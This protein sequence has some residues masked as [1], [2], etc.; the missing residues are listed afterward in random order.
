MQLIISF[1]NENKLDDSIGTWNRERNGRKGRKR[2]TNWKAK[3]GERKSIQR[4]SNSHVR[5]DQL[6]CSWSR[7]V[8]W[9]GERAANA[10]VEK[11]KVKVEFAGLCRRPE[12]CVCRVLGAA[13]GYISLSGRRKYR[14]IPGA[15]PREPEGGTGHGNK[16][17]AV[18]DRM[19]DV[20]SGK[21]NARFAAVTKWQIGVET[22][23]VRVWDRL[24]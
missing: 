19:I 2:S 8:E 14:M 17:F 11:L 6:K 13:Q 1:T 5:N 4:R 12:S 16:S 10:I 23:L 15:D 3:I 20:C 21:K 18:R 24:G 7:G 22:S 9:D